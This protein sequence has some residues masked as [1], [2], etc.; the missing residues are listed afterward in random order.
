MKWNVEACIEPGKRGIVSILDAETGE[1]A[2]AK[3]KAKHGDAYTQYMA[4]PNY[5]STGEINPVVWDKD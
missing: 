2:I 5:V 1:E 3:A 4:A